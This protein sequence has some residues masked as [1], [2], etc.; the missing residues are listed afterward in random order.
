MPSRPAR[1]A[2][3]RSCRPP[4]W[5]ARRRTGWPR[6]WS[7]TGSSRRDLQ[8]RFV[9][10]PRLRELAAAAGEDRLLEA[11]NPVLAR[12]RDITGES[13]Q[14]YRRQGDSRVCVAAAERLTGLR[15]TVPVGATLTMKAGSAAQI[16]LAW[17]EPDRLHRGLRE[18]P[19]HRDGAVRASGAGA[20]RRASGEREPG[21]ASVSAPVRGPAGR[22]VAAVSVSGPDRAAD[23]PARPA[24]RPDRLRGGGQAQRG[25]P[26][27]PATWAAGTAGAADGPGT[28]AARLTAAVKPGP[29]GVEAPVRPDQDRSA[30]TAGTSE[31]SVIGLITT[32]V[33][34]VVCMYAVVDPLLQVLEIQ[35]LADMLIESSALGAG[36]VGALWFMVLRP[37]RGDA[38][39]ERDLNRR[40]AQ[41][42]VDDI[43]RQ[44][45]DSRVSR[46]MDM[47]GTEATGHHATERALTRGTPR[48][49][50]EL[51]LADSSDA[52]LHAAHAAPDGSAPG[53]TVTSPRDCPPSGA[54]RPCCSHP[55]KRSTPAPTSP[56]APTVTAPPPV[57]RS[58]SAAA[59]SASSTPPSAPTRPYPLEVSR[60]ES[61]A[62]Q[63][64][65]RL[66]MLRVME[67]THL[68]AATDPLTGLLNRRSFENR[69]QDLLRRGS[70]FTSRWRPGPLQGPQRQARARRRRPGPAPVLPHPWRRGPLRR[71][72]VP[73]RRGGVR[74]RLP[75]PAGGG[76]D[77][78][79][80]RIQEQLVLALSAGTVPPFTA[81]FG[82]AH[83]HDGDTLEDICR[84]A[85]AALFRAN[86]EGRNRVTV[87]ACAGP[88]AEPVPDAGPSQ[89]VSP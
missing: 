22:V 37:L 39:R 78:R 75:G 28:D 65:A 44:E 52:N 17:E 61:L 80:G 38:A 1:P 54:A 73:L 51:L 41:Q 11:A 89:A 43:E 48:L 68:Q 34:V 87:D 6:R 46:A 23:P 45:F 31:R 40:R 53:C 64:G 85:D 57:S 77:P 42:L 18:R 81:S 69:V 19:L 76:G 47:A 67:A 79:L 63:A 4:G 20:G 25:P 14:L 88:L 56:D 15:D 49:A 2:S 82:V 32:V 5:P 7:T 24:A 70:P 84:A 58:A 12:L 33:A 3:P 66:G 29:I 74:R 50:A 62:T 16:L 83:S 30:D 35:G 8:G 59:A 71:P 27:G 55:A 13:A 72:R 26:A 9:L 10:G 36:T 21:V 60:L 86:R